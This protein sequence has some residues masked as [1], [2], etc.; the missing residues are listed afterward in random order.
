MD[1]IRVAI[2]YD[3][4]KTLSQNDMQSYGFIKRIG[5]DI[6]DFWAECARFTAKHTS[7]NILSY[8]YMIL[9]KCKEKG[10]KPTKEFFMDCAKDIEY[11]NG[12]DTYFDNLNK[13]AESKGVILE[14]YIISSG[15]KEM[16]EGSKIAK[17]FK[18]I[19]ACSYA[20]D[21]NGEAFWPAIDINYTN[22][23]QFLYRIN[24]GIYSP[25]DSS[26]NNFMAHDERPIPFE[27][28]IYIG[29]S[30]TDIPSMKLLRAKHGI[31]IGVYNADSLPDYYKALINQNRVDYIA[32]ADY[33]ENSELVN[34]LKEIIE[35]MYHK[36]K[37]K[38]LN[39]KQRKI[40]SEN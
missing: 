11:F 31:S 4:D 38:K 5:M 15:L 37:L 14:H 18:E 25:T 3:F 24:K 35:T 27:N 10:I 8:L 2:C 9:E 7:S 12:I 29:D 19:Y 40:T 16:I 26:V 22:K 28:I 6:D 23:T 39:L 32:K 13:F 20:Y 30:E 34:I 21:E 33:S 1:K 36:D 17:H